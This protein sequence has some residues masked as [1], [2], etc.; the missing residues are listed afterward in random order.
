MRVHVQKICFCERIIKI[1]IFYFTIIFIPE[2]SRDI[3]TSTS[4]SSESCGRQRSLSFKIKENV[5][6]PRFRKKEGDVIETAAGDEG[7]REPYLG[8]SVIFERPERVSWS[9]AATR[10]LQ[11]LTLDG[12]QRMA[13]LKDGRMSKKLSDEVTPIYLYNTN[14]ADSVFINKVLVDEALAV[15]NVL[16]KT[17]DDTSYSGILCFYLCLSCLS[18]HHDHVA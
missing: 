16:P 8:S 4:S 13:S 2:I 10:R 9:E 1:R 18:L 15:S 3:S 17:T 7:Y 14:A 11:E 6:G 5:K 12:K